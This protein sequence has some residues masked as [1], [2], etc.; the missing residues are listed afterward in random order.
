MIWSQHDANAVRIGASRPRVELEA[1]RQGVERRNQVTHT[2]YRMS[3]ACC[4]GMLFLEFDL[5]RRARMTLGRA[6]LGM[7]EG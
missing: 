6:S 3:R 5:P 7:Q 2:D 1:G 4:T